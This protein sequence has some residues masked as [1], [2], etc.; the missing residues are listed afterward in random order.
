MEAEERLADYLVR[1]ALPHHRLRRLNGGNDGHSTN[2]GKFLVPASHEAPGRR[3]GAE[4]VLRGFLHPPLP[5]HRWRSLR[6]AAIGQDDCDLRVSCTAI[7]LIIFRDAIVKEQPRYFWNRRRRVI[8]P[9]LAGRPNM[10]D[11]ANGTR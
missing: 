7:A 10:I 2:I 9:C 8:K 1:I 5:N 4:S 11:L 6:P 3:I